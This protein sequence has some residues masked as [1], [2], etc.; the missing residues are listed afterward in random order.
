MTQYEYQVIASP[1]RTKRI[2]GVKTGAGRFAHAL[3]DAINDMA[4]EGWEYL[5]AET[6]PAD[7]KKGMLSSASE[8]YHSVLVFRRAKP[9]AQ[10]QPAL[11][12]APVK[13]EPVL[14]EPAPAAP[15]LGPADR[16][17]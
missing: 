17:L 12:A 4:A 11:R 14:S 9:A 15:G 2:K 16:D 3:T 7:E 6:L 10:V 5:R 1:R 8:T 13:P